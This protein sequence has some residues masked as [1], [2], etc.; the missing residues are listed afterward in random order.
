MF[1]HQQVINTK[2]Y[3]IIKIDYTVY[4]LN[5]AAR[6]ITKNSKIHILLSWGAEPLVTESV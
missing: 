2:H 3:K 6:N 1:I 4:K 5:F